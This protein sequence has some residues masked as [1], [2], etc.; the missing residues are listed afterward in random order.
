MTLDVLAVSPEL[1]PEDSISLVAPAG[2][3]WGW[4]DWVQL[5][6]VKAPVEPTEAPETTP[7]TAAALQPRSP[8]DGAGNPGSVLWIVLAAAMVLAGIA[9]AAVLIPKKKE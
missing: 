6:K 9:I 3:Y 7:S 1:K 4:V 8:A 2:S 5:E